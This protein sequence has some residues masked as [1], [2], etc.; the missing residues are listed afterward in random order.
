MHKQS[1][2]IANAYDAV[3]IEDLNIQ[4]MAQGLSFTKST[5]D[6]GFGMLKIFKE[7]KLKEQGKQLIVIDKCYLSSKKCH[8][9][10]TIN[11]ELMLADRVW[12][13][14]AVQ[15]MTGIKM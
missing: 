1:R 13:C 5:N 2:Q 12:T 9:C 10:G 7:Y 15:S 6:N 3:V 4:G 14:G 11:N 8:I